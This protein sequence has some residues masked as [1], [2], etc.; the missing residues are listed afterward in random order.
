MKATIRLS[1]DVNLNMRKEYSRRAR[2]QASRAAL[3][4]RFRAHPF[5]RRVKIQ[6][7]FDNAALIKLQCE[8]PRLL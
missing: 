3:R 8:H 1:W 5:A 4:S 6:P 2:V 7:L